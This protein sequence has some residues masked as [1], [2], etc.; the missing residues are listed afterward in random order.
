MSQ[1]YII[2]GS[3]VFFWQNKISIT[4]LLTL[5]IEL[6]K[7]GDSFLCL[8]DANTPHQINRRLKNRRTKEN[9][10]YAYQQL[11]K[12]EQ[13]FSEV[14]GGI[15]ADEFILAQANHLNCSIVSNDRF[16]DYEDRY[17]WVNVRDTKR[18]IRGSVLGGFLNMP[19]L[20]I[21][22]PVENDIDKLLS[23]LKRSLAAKKSHR[24]QK[25]H[26]EQKSYREQQSHREQ[27]SRPEQMSHSSQPSHSSQ[28]PHPD[29]Q[30]HRDQP[31]P[32]GRLSSAS[33]KS[34]P[35]SLIIFRL[36]EAQANSFYSTGFDNQP[37]V[38]KLQ[39][40]NKLEIRGRFFQFVRLKKTLPPNFRVSI[41]FKTVDPVSQF[42]LGIGDGKNWK[43]GYH[44]VMTP[45]WAAIQK[46][47][48]HGDDWSE[49]LRVSHEPNHFV[50]VGTFPIVFDRQ[51]GVLKVTL[52]QQTIFTIDNQK[53]INAFNHLCLTS[54][55]AVSAKAV[56]ADEQQGTIIIEHLV[57]RKLA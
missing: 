4:P 1:H 20:G 3:N 52:G 6:R 54:D 57:V 5:L 29:Q 2:D 55:R 40:G 15:N 28:Q 14:P 39:P 36:S 22:V 13:Y 50:S 9:T 11:L 18:L 41:L 48:D 47:T 8:F 46:R 53:D 35:K 17:P 23:Q 49:F 38:F 44:F 42:I 32:S 27:Q 56:A 10:K 24:R 16:R 7:R 31:S 51:N 12:K 26:G 43:S 37:A 34:L 33:A 21:V 19:Q 45:S 25:S 30:P